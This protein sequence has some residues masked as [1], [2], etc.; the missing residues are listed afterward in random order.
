MESGSLY[1]VYKQQKVVLVYQFNETH[2]QRG[3]FAKVV[4]KST[5]YIKTY[6]KKK[7]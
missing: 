6:T 7:I 3:R 2:K 4:W 5:Q 1:L